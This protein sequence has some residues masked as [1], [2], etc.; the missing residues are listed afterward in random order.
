MSSGRLLLAV[1]VTA[2]MLVAPVMFVELAIARPPLAAA[3]RAYDVDAG[4]ASQTTRGLP[5]P[6]R[7]IPNALRRGVPCA[8]DGAMVTEKDTVSAGPA[9]ITRYAFGLRSDDGAE[10]IATLAGD[11]AVELFNATQSGDR[12]V[13]QTLRG[14]VALVGDGSR[15][16]ATDANPDTPARN[17]AVALWTTG[18]LCA[19]EVLALAIFIAVRRRRA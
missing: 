15:T 4:C 12:V 14:R 11:R 8:L 19:L 5:S 16:V 17:N 1:A 2:V 9:G 10:Y 3:A 13:V 18:V 6:T 7:P